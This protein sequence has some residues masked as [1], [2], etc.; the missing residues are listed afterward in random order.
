MGCERKMNPSNR[1]VYD[2]LAHNGKQLY[3]SEMK[4][5]KLDYLPSTQ[6]LVYSFW[7]QSVFDNNGKLFLHVYPKDLQTLPDNRKKYGFLN[8]GIG[9]KDIQKVDSTHFY[10]VKDLSRY[11][12]VERLVTGQYID[13]KR[14]WI[15][16]ERINLVTK[17]DDSLENR[18]NKGIVENLDFDFVETL[19]FNNSQS[20]YADLTTGINC[21]ISLDQN[22]LYLSNIDMNYLKDNFEFRFYGSDLVNKNLMETKNLT[23]LKTYCTNSQLCFAYT[24]IPKGITRIS[25]VRS[26]KSKIK[27]LFSLNIE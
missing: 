2:F 5:T 9:K 27:E 20:H 22:L 25:F 12:I 16:D 13:N 3:K 23:K 24:E 7:K 11:G 18:M 10:I 6:K 17:Y 8:I 14:T 4:R 26:E 21:F 19:L 1:F 15:V